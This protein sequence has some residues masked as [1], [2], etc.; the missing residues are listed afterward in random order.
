MVQADYT[1]GEDLTFLGRHT[2]VVVLNDRTGRSQLAV[3]PAWQ[4][5]AMTST[6]AGIDGPSF[7]WINRDLI[8]SGKL[9]P[10]INAY[11]GEDRFWLGPEGSQFSIYFAKDAPF[12]AENWFVPKPLDTMPF[13]T[14]RQSQDSALFEAHFS[15]ENRAG[16]QFD[17]A[18]RREICLLDLDNAWGQLGLA[19]VQG[20][21]MVA[22]ESDNQLGND[23]KDVWQRESGLLSVW[24]LG[25]FKA[26][27]DTVV[28]IPI[29]SGS[30]VDFGSA[31]TRYPDYGVIPDDRLSTIENA[32]FFRGDAIRRGKIGINPRRTRGLIA[33]YDAGRQLLSIVQFTQP[34][35]ETRY[36]NSIWGHQA[37]P[38]GGDAV[39]SYND[40]P[41]MQG[42]AQ[43]GKFYELE[44]S[45]PAASLAPSAS[46]KHIHRTVHLSGP[47]ASLDH[48][49]R[50]VLGLSLRSIT[51]G[52]PGR[53]C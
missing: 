3:A 48:V 43:L 30:G 35:G 13:R 53:E 11:G 38:Y 20:V 8:A 31:V 41:P 44:S 1:F 23:G 19:P 32:V 17:V 14:L 28:V 15:L 47:E 22:Y 34:T 7:G 50:K 51:E 9:M 45:S 25:M 24:I 37:E 33:S 18:V 40:G 6:P 16:T 49:A 4:G 46:I 39:N 27:P 5:R 2:E 42:G 10:H 52:L 21:S 36:V 29:R 26:S 12:A